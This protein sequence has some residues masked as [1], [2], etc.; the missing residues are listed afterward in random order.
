MRKKN[1]IMIFYFGAVEIIELLG[2][3]QHNNGP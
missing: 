3:S 2:S 1:L